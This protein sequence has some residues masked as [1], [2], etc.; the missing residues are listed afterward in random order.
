MKNE[1]IEI[2]LTTKD[3][4]KLET[5]AGMQGITT[6][7]LIRAWITQEYDK[8]LKTLNTKNNAKNL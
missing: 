6:S 7:Y 4:E 3:K 5:L 8:A 2:R 1:R